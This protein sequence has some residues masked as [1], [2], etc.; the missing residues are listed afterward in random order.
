MGERVI[1]CG[2]PF[3]SH[4][5][6]PVYDHTV[7]K[8]LLH[9]SNGRRDIAWLDGQTLM[10]FKPL[11]RDELTRCVTDEKRPRHITQAWGAFRV[12]S[13]PLW[14]YE[15]PGSVAVALARNGVVVADSS[16]VVALDLE[17]GREL[18]SHPL[19][20]APVAWGLAVDRGGRVIV[21]LADGQVLSI[22]ETIR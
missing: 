13:R 11:N 18:W 2:R 16:S 17:G 22:G 3:Y 21:T 10:C 1:A 6:V 12:R 14:R 4:P 5:D 9:A 19:P 20:A 8:K 15:R 7:T